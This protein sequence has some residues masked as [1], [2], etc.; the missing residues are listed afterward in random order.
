MNRLKNRSNKVLLTVLTV[1]YVNSANI[2]QRYQSQIYKQIVWLQNPRT[3]WLYLHIRVHPYTRSHTFRRSAISL[4]GSNCLVALVFI[5]QKASGIGNIWRPHGLNFESRTQWRKW[6]KTKKSP[7]SNQLKNVPASINRHPHRSAKVYH[8]FVRL[9]IV[10]ILDHH[11]S[12][13]TTSCPCFQYNR[14]RP[15]AAL[16]HP[17]TTSHYHCSISAY[18]PFHRCPIYP[19]TMTRKTATTIMIM[20]AFRW[21]R[22]MHKSIR[23][24]RLPNA[25]VKDWI[26]RPYSRV[27]FWKHRQRNDDTMRGACEKSIRSPSNG[28]TRMWWSSGRKTKCPTIRIDFVIFLKIK[29][30][31]VRRKMCLVLRAETDWQLW[32]RTLAFSAQRL[33]C[34]FFFFWKLISHNIYQMNCTLLYI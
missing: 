8:H 16:C 28:S 12:S 11:T 22:S 4:T 21:R 18:R 32:G 3:N 23:R 10:F 17:S 33:H 7:W 25:Q 20:I 2:I 14:C 5:R 27:S 29:L 13:P 6:W 1:F 15:A 26:W 34:A 9:T 24:H 19:A 31:F 30:I